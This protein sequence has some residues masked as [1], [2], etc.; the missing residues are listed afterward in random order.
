MSF[1]PVGFQEG[2]ESGL[3]GSGFRGGGEA[4]T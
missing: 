3:D 1:G 2:T 4:Q